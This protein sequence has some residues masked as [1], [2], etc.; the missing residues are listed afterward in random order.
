MPEGFC[1]AVRRI[2]TV[3]QGDVDH[4]TIGAGEFLCRQRHTTG[5][6]VFSDGHAAHGTEDTLIIERRKSSFICNLPNIQILCQILLNIINGSLKTID[7]V[8]HNGHLVPLI[9]I[10][11][12]QGIFI[13]TFS[14]LFV[15]FIKFIFFLY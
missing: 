11:S 9:F 8:F 1:K 5:A 3:L 10:I 7:P 12:H 15:G 4:L 2:I 13:P 14:A 6:D